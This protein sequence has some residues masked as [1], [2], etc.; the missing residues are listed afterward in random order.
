MD[1]SFFLFYPLKWCENTGKKNSTVGMVFCSMNP[2][3]GGVRVTEY[4]LVVARIKMKCNAHKKSGLMS[5]L[6]CSSPSSR[7]AI[8]YQNFTKIEGKKMNLDVVSRLISD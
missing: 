8:I 2:K 5:H 1:K 3:I 4:F 6:I 7:V